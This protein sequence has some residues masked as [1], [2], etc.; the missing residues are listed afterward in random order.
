MTVKKNVFVKKKAIFFEKVL[1]DPN[2]RMDSQV[3]VNVRIIT[4]EDIPKI[5]AKFEVFKTATIE[6]RFQAGHVG[7]GA[8]LGGEIVHVSWF[9]FGDVFVDSLRRR[10]RLDSE[11]A[12]VYD[13]FTLPE[14]RGLGII[15]KTF[16]EALQYLYTQRGIKK[17]YVAISHANF[18]MQKV[19]QREG[20]RKIGAITYT[21]IMKWGVIRF[22]GATK[23]D[24]EHLKKMFSL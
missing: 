21:R 2:F 14:C 16:S 11:S 18:P 23:E 5:E 20:L 8:E 13:G 15:G 10:M 12:Y 9:S 17:F 3:D 24:R 19:V 7:F 22:E 1:P 6:E 4:A